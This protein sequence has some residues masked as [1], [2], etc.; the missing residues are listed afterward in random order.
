MDRPSRL[1]RAGRPG[2]LIRTTPAFVGR[3]EE[4]AWIE[5]CLQETVAGHPRVVLIPGEAGIG[6]TR[7][8]HEVRSIALRRDMQVCYGRCY[9]DLAL[10]YLPFVEILRPYLE[11]LSEDMQQVLGA[12]AEILG[13]LLYHAGRPLSTAAL[14][15]S[16]Q[17]EQDKLQLFLAA[18]HTITKFAQKSPHAPRY[19]RSA[20]G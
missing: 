4:L 13:Q 18:S 1:N 10:P 7:L 19:G 20:L 17:T 16:A 2:S 6:K 5:R 15:T 8:L 14:S 9:E 3:R 12:D 11:Q